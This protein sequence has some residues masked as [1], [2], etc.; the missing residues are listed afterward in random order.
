MIIAFF[1]GFLARFFFHLIPRLLI[2]SFLITC[3]YYVFSPSF[4]QKIHNNIE[5]DK[6]ENSFNPSDVVASYY[7]EN[8][9]FH[10]LIK[11]GTKAKIYNFEFECDYLEN[12]IGKHFR[13]VSFD[14]IKPNEIDDIK[15]NMNVK[16][17]KPSCISHF[18]YDKSDLFKA[19]GRT[20]LNLLSQIN[21]KIDIEY[22][23]KNNHLYDIIYHIFIDNNS[24]IDINS[25]RTKCIV[26]SEYMSTIEQKIPSMTSAVVSKTIH[27]VYHPYDTQNLQAICNI[28]KVN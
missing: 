15:V 17:T 8:N 13:A 5:K 3:V 16:N 1:I 23:Q 7:I 4:R 10:A 18:E 19:F 26:D 12:D 27:N 25:I 11:N 14:T 21:S 6:I 9:I 2:V 22:I 28:V 24:K 20:D